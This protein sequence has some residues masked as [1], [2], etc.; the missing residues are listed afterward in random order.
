MAAADVE[1]DLHLHVVVVSCSVLAAKVGRMGG[2]V[3]R[4]GA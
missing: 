2:C 3:A 4:A 1:T